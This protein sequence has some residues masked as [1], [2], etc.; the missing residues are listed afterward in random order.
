MPYP[1]PEL[2]ILW[3]RV[4]QVGLYIQSARRVI[5]QICR[6]G[7]EMERAWANRNDRKQSV[8]LLSWKRTAAPNYCYSQGHRLGSITFITLPVSVGLKWL[9]R[10]L[11]FIQLSSHWQNREMEKYDRVS[12]GTQSQ[13]WLCRRE[14]AGILRINEEL[15]G[16][17]SSGSGLEN[18]DK[19]P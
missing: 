11:W 19:R 10:S 14:P 12:H 15:L 3:G 16:K 5:T 7:E 18:G 6:R 13:E 1:S 9:P 4:V 8:P 17:K 2:K